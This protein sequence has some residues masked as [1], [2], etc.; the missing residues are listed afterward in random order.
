MEDISVSSKNP[1]PN[2]T[3]RSTNISEVHSKTIKPT[4]FDV[5]IIA[6]IPVVISYAEFQLHIESRIKLPC[7]ATYVR[8]SRKDVRINSCK[9]FDPGNHRAGNLYLKGYI[10]ESL[11]YAELES[12]NKESSVGNICNMIVDIPFECNVRVNYIMSPVLKTSDRL[13]HVEVVETNEMANNSFNSIISSDSP[14]RSSDLLFELEESFIL[15]SSITTDCSSDCKEIL[16]DSILQDIVVT[17]RFSLLQNQMV[18]VSA[19]SQ[20]IR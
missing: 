7:L 16:F 4:I 2:N 19:Y 8:D 9:L 12:T 14:G 15:D 10:S 17:I 13:L 1:Q 11:E 20:Y 3:C 18:K 5:P 6:K